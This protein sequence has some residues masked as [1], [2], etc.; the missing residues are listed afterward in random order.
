MHGLKVKSDLHD[1]LTNFVAST[2]LET[3]AR[4]KAVCSDGGGKYTGKRTQEYLRE[5]RIRHE[6]TTADTPQHNGVTE[7]LNRT[8]VE[9]A[10]TLLRSLGTF[11]SYVIYCIYSLACTL[12]L[13]RIN[14][15]QRHAHCS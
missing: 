8:L 10:R 9:T 14:A 12:V 5:H 2:K 13:C 4:V 11:V 7:R 15:S 1:R 3:R 6:M